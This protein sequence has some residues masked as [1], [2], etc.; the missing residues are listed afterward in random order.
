VFSGDVAQQVLLAQQLDLQACWLDALDRMQ[1][2]AEM[3]IGAATSAATIR[4]E[5]VILLNMQFPYSTS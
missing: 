3:H 4:S 1:V 5:I 2:R